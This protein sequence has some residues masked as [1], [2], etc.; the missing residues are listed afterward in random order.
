[1]T[2]LRHFQI[3]NVTKCIFPEPVFVGSFGILAVRIALTSEQSKAAIRSGQRCDAR[4]RN[5]AM[6]ECLSSFRRQICVKIYAA[7]WKRPPKNVPVSHT[8]HAGDTAAAGK[9]G[10]VDPLRI[11]AKAL[12]DIMAGIHRQPETIE[13]VSLI[14]RVVSADQEQFVSG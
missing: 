2:H 13:R 10:N 8:K 7:N 5:I 11:E 1:M 4:I 3:E 14:A 9:T 12:A 6:L